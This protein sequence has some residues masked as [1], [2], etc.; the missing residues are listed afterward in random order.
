MVVGSLGITGKNGSKRSNEEGDRMFM[1]ASVR[2]G[3]NKLKQKIYSIDI[4]ILH[5]LFKIVYLL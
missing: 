1:Q 4:Y 3:I 5:L 2:V